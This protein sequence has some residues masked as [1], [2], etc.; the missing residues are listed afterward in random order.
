MLSKHKTTKQTTDV[1]LNP[2]HA[3]INEPAATNFATSINHFPNSFSL[4]YV[5][6]FLLSCQYPKKTY[7]LINFISR[8]LSY[9]LFF[10]IFSLPTHRIRDNSR[11]VLQIYI[12]YFI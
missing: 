6:L 4:F 2:A 9:E 11:I 10:I 8:L 1:L 3:I 12:I 5:Y 7:W